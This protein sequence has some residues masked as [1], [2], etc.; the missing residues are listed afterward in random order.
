MSVVWRRASELVIGHRRTR[1]DCRRTTGK[2][3]HVATSAH[4]AD[5]DVE[6]SVRSECDYSAIVDAALWLPRILLDCANP[7]HVLI[8]G[9]R[10][11]IPLEAVDPVAQEGRLAEHVRVRAGRTLG[12]VQVDTRV[13]REVRMQR[14]PEQTP[15][16]AKVDRQVQHRALDLAV[17]ALDAA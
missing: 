4:I 7:D 6:L 16:G 3:L 8:K 5:E 1:A 9:E 10:R 15:L 13:R 14:D 17:H 11:S 2:V 12:P